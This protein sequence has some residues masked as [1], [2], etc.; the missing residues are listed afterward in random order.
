MASALQKQLQQL[1]AAKPAAKQ[2]ASVLIH[3]H[4]VDDVV[5]CIFPYHETPEFASVGAILHYRNKPDIAFLEYLRSTKL[6]LDRSNL[7]RQCSKIPALQKRICDM[8]KASGDKEFHFASFFSR[9]MVAA[10]DEV[11]V[12]EEFLRIA[13]EASLDALTAGKSDYSK[14]RNTLTNLSRSILEHL[15]HLPPHVNSE[16]LITAIVTTAINISDIGHGSSV[17]ELIEKS[18]F[19]DAS[20]KR[21]CDVITDKLRELDNAK[22]IKSPSAVFCIDALK[23]LCAKFPISLATN[24]IAR[25]RE[26]DMLRDIVFAGLK[27]AD[28]IVLEV[29]KLESLYEILSEEYLSKELR[30]LAATRSTPVKKAALIQIVK[31]AKA[32]EMKGYRVRSELLPY[33]IPDHKE[34]SVLMQFI[35]LVGSYKLSIGTY[36]ENISKKIQLID[37]EIKT[38]SKKSSLAKLE[39]LI[40]DFLQ[41]VA[42]TGKELLID[43][44]YIC[45]RMSEVLDPEAKEK[46]LAESV[47]HFLLSHILAAPSHSIKLGLLNILKTVDTPLK[48]KSLLPLIEECFAEKSVAKSTRTAGLSPLKLALACCFT[49][50]ACEVLFSIKSGRYLRAF[51]ILLRNGNAAETKLALDQVG[52][53]CIIRLPQ[54]HQLSTFWSFLEVIAG[55]D[56]FTAPLVKEVLAKMNVSSEILHLALGQCHSVI[57]QGQER[58]S[59]K[60]KGEGA[61]V[62]SILVAVLEIIE[63]KSAVA[64]TNEIIGSLFDLIGDVVAAPVKDVSYPIEYL[65]QLLVSVCLKVINTLET[66]ASL[67]DSVLKMSEDEDPEASEL[68]KSPLSTPVNGKTLRFFKLL[69]V[70]AVSEMLARRSLV[71]KLQQQYSEELQ[72]LLLKFVES[73]LIFIDE[74]NARGAADVSASITKYNR[75]V[76]KRL[77]SVLSALNALLPYKSFLT[78]ALRLMDSNDRSVSRRIILLLAERISDSPPEDYAAIQSLIHDIMKKLHALIKLGGTG[79]DAQNE[80][81]V[82]SAVLI[83]IDALSVFCAKKDPEIF[84]PLMPNLLSDECALH[85][86]RRIRS[87]SIGCVTTLCVQLGPRLIPFLPRLINVALADIRE[88]HTDKDEIAFF[89]SLLVTIDTLPLFVGSFIPEVFN[90]LLG[91]DFEK[92]VDPTIQNQV[93]TLVLYIPAAMKANTVSTQLLSKKQDVLSVVAEKLPSRTLVPIFKKAIPTLL[94]DAKA[95]A[96]GPRKA[97][98]AALDFISMMGIFVERME[99]GDVLQYSTEVVEMFLKLLDFR[100]VY[101]GALAA[102]AVSKVETGAISAFM[103]FILR[104]NE[105]LF[106]P[107]YLNLRSWLED[108]RIQKDVQKRTV[109]FYRVTEALLVKLKSIFAPH[110]TLMVDVAVGRLAQY[111]ESFVLDE[112]WALVLSCLTKYFAYVPQFPFEIDKFQNVYNPICDQIENVALHGDKPLD[113]AVQHVIPCIAQL[114]VS[115]GKEVFWKPLNKCILMKTRSDDARVRLI[116]VKVLTEFYMRLGEEFLVLLPETV[117]FMA[118]LMEDNVEAVQRACHELSQEIQK[119]LGEDLSTYFT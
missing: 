77:H 40:S 93:G 42:K 30:K 63:S 56:S 103:Q 59:K 25:F 116:C 98:V 104:L 73:I 29:L 10:I 32:K 53:D 88:N 109:T 49:R 74:F 33:L 61:D 16:P 28:S 75:G 96:G 24:V 117:P 119:H 108:R 99:K 52:N 9:T 22:K 62:F 111:K 54:A 8:F 58:F 95:I 85:Q 13:I 3:V 7:A 51:I 67:T 72:T 27:D 97:E 71:R 36:W 55:G 89:D 23:R 87:L 18:S 64:P 60:Q 45:K 43:P 2:T 65:K 38:L 114:A 113:Q 19:S 79:A 20:A 11:D 69:C 66:L 5:N 48:V 44:G 107:I 81:D 12:D 15:S 84:L 46:S 94:Q 106:K 91:N 90:A 102:E 68:A 41:G 6:P 39:S 26:L 1:S 76:I 100:R 34:P 115:A 92:Q 50:K 78:V 101:E 70:E 4:N 118:E 21:L 105:S 112:A 31:M 86:A 82:R 80:P 37:A 35:E 14:V 110:F 83:C 57:S 17:L 47:T